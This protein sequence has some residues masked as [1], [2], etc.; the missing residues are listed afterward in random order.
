MDEI[1]VPPTRARDEESSTHVHDGPDGH[2]QAD[3]RSEHIYDQ[4]DES[5]LPVYENLQR[6]NTRNPH[7]SAADDDYISVL[8]LNVVAGD[9]GTQ[10]LDDQPYLVPKVIY[11]DVR[12]DMS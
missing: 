4:F 6:P 8:D 2:R 5:R 9:S 7:P 11:M 3:R 1:N 12:K 10:G